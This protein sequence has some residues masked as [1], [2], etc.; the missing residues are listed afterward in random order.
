MGKKAQFLKV[1]DVV[2]IH[3]NVKHW[4]GA[5]KDSWFSHIAITAG[6]AEWFEE[7]SDEEYDKL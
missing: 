4:H 6:D 5:T 3:E 7:V 1:G 2:T